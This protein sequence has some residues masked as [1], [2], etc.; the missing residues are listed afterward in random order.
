MIGV[1]SAPIVLLVG[2]SLAAFA[3]AA[4]FLRRRRDRPGAKELGAILVAVGT[5]CVLYAAQLAI[6]SKTGMIFIYQLIYFCIVPLPALWFKFVTSYTGSKPLPLG[7]WAVG[8]VVSTG[9]VMGALLWPETT[10]VWTAVSVVSLGELETLSL[11]KGPVFYAFLGYSYLLFGWGLVRLGRKGITNRGTLRTQTR[12]IGLAL[13]VVLVPNLAY[14]AGVAPLAFDPTPFAFTVA[15]LLFVVADSQYGLFRSHPLARDIAREHV[16]EEMVDGVFVVDRADVVTDINPAAAEALGVSPQHIVGRQLDGVL[17]ALSTRIEAAPTEQPT[18][19]HAPN[20]RNY[21]V[22]LSPLSD[23]TDGIQ[24]S[25]VTLHDVTETRQR[26]ERLAVLNRILRHDI[27]NGLNVVGGYA[28]LMTEPDADEETKELA[29]ARVKDRTNEL[30]EL[31]E[32]IR[33]IEKGLDRHAE[34]QTVEL[35]QVLGTVV[36][37]VDRDWPDA[38][39][40]LSG[41]DEVVVVATSIVEALFDNLVE[42]AAEHGGTAPNID[43]QVTDDDGWVSIDIADD[44]PGVPPEEL[45]VIEA[46]ETQLHHTSGIG[47]W[48]VTWLVRQSNGT[49]DFDVS[50]S[51]TTVC[52]RLKRA[53]EDAVSVNV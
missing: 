43:V 40:S 2:V 42:N 8:L 44:G 39:L 16:L 35:M 32:K 14:N 22:T 31:A 36:G 13:F 52:V 24:G 50:D 46:G 10:L 45:S 30:L 33:T 7:G 38:S 29:G 25:V 28:E 51:G 41:P 18:T 37:R 48:L 23:S 9:Y 20:E 12:S 11:G 15:I 19:Y 47:L 26:E 6:S 34:R 21:D 3:I 49:I 27:R 53:S 17:P 5:W 4:T 1:L